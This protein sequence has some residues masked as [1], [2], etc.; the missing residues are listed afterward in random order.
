VNPKPQPKPLSGIRVIDFTSLVA[1]PW[2]TRLL[3]DCGAEVIKVEA[4]GDGDLLRLSPP[5][6]GGI[7]RVYAHFNC[8]KRAITLDLKSTAGL[9]VAR[10][11]VEAAD[12]VVENYRP[13][14]MA[15]LGLDY[16]AVRAANPKIVYC[17]VSGFGQSGPRAGQA[18]YAPVVHALSGFDHV[19][20]RAQGADAPPVSGIMI[21]DVLAGAYAFGA[22]QTALVGRERH[23]LGCHIDTTLM[24]SMMSLVAIQYQEAQSPTPIGSRRFRPVLARDG[25]VVVPLVSLKTYLALFTVIDRPDW[26]DEFSTMKAVMRHTAEIDAAVAAWAEFRSVEDIVQAM[27][28]AGVPC[29]PY[30]SPADMLTDGPLMERGAFAAIAGAGGDYT[31]L[32]PPFRFAGLDCVAVPQVSGPGENTADVLRSVLGMNDEER[33]TAGRE[34]AFG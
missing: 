21:A 29:S 14:V 32:N 16:E 28:G 6:E 31:V 15:R 18:A 12:V 3:A 19:F 11:L 34:G 2:C 25:F 23:G 33:E 17:S 1:G 10:R 9:G 8:G 22:V 5:V 4:K 24:E 26:Q 27:A 30:R 13:G 20:M 7:S